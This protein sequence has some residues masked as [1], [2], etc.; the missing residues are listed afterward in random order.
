M[1][2]RIKYLSLF[3]LLVGSSF[4]QVREYF[5]IDTTYFKRCNKEAIRAVI[6]ADKR[7]DSVIVMLQRLRE[8]QQIKGK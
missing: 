4:A 1:K 7:Y 2:N 8:K 3:I 5:Q 6:E